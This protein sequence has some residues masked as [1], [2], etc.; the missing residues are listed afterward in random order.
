M[1]SESK[2]LLDI[3][4]LDG[5]VKRLDEKTAGLLVDIV[6]DFLKKPQ[7]KEAETSQALS[8]DG[9]SVYSKTTVTET[10][11]QTKIIQRVKRPD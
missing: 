8:S 7:P 6:R 1:A 5:I 4:K 2:F 3:D 10:L 9:F 11:L